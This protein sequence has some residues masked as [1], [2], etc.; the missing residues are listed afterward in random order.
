MKLVLPLELIQFSIWEF[1]MQ[2]QFILNT[3]TYDSMLVQANTLEGQFEFS[4]VGGH[5]FAFLN[6]AGSS[7]NPNV[8]YSA[9]GIN[10]IDIGVYAIAYTTTSNSI[11]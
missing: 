10:T 8:I 5:Q 6:G 4:S 2:K 1:M 11:R 9:I 3:N 7:V